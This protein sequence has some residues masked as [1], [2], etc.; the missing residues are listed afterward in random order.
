[1]QRTRAKDEIPAEL[2]HIPGFPYELWIFYEQP[3][4]AYR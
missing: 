3:L 1:M 2:G 4:Y